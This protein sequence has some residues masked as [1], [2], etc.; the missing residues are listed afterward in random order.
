MSLI[1]FIEK[2]IWV[3]NKDSSVEK[4]KL[5]KSQKEFLEMMKNRK[6]KKDGSNWLSS[7]CMYKLSELVYFY[8]PIYYKNYVTV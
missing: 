2:Y 8:V 5:R 4:L 1:E 7:F 3:R 6:R